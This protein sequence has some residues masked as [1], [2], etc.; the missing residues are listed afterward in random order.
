MVLGGQLPLPPWP[1][2][3]GGWSGSE[4]GSQR[5]LWAGGQGTGRAGEGSE[6][7][8]TGRPVCPLRRR[9]WARGRGVQQNWPLKPGT[10]ERAS[11]LNCHPIHRLRA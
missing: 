7:G 1:R 6:S 2:G 10:P 11:V 8:R 3:L 9:Q 4:E 5:F